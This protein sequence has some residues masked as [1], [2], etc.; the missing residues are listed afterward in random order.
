MK[1]LIY[2]I[3]IILLFGVNLGLFGNLPIFGQVPNLLFLLTMYLALEKK[4]YDFLFVAFICGIFLDFFS[5][6]FF[7]GFTFSLLIT[8]AVLHVISQNFILLELD[9][10]FLVGLLLGSMALFKL[11]LWLYIFFVTISHLYA[12]NESLSMYFRNFAWNYLYN[13]LLIYPM[14]FFYG[15]LRKLIDG[16]KVRKHGLGR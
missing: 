15:Y 1:Y 14:Y 13:L 8:S 16:I 4:D 11:L 9:W 7:G 6:S 12:G 10:K 3:A 2:T 5:A